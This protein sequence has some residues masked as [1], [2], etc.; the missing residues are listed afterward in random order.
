MYAENQY[1]TVQYSTGSSENHEEQ[2]YEDLMKLVP[3]VITELEEMK[4]LYVSQGH[5]VGNIIYELGEMIKQCFLMSATWGLER[6]EKI[7][8]VETD[9][10]LTYEQRREILVA[11]ICGQGTTTCKMIE[12]TAAAFSGGEVEVIEDNINYCFTIRFIGI[13]GIP[14]NMNGFINMLEEIKPAHMAYEFQY[15]YTIWN[16]LIS[17]DWNSL[18]SRS[19]DDV[20]VLF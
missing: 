6:W 8:G 14:R 2:K 10:F 9:M 15:R 4:A 7:L 13:K 5:E 19:W 3:N 20:R 16:E 12:E 18:S 17:Y 1:G 11:K